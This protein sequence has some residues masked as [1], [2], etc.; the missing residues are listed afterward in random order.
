VLVLGA[1]FALSGALYAALATPW[2]R[3]EVLMAQ[4]KD[5][6]TDGLMS[7]FGGLASLA[8]INVGSSDNAEPLALLKS[9]GFARE[10][11]EEEKLETVLLSRKWNAAEKRWK[12]PEEDWPDVRD[13]VEYFDEKVRRVVPDKKTGLVTLAVEWK[14]PAVAA[15]WANKMASRLNN[16]MRE[17]AIAE[18]TE[19]IRYLKSEMAQADLIS[20][21][22]SI[23]KILEVELQKLMLA[24]NNQQ[25]S[26][27][28]IDPAQVPKKKVRPLVIPF[29]AVGGFLGLLLG[30]V[31]LIG[32]V[33]LQRVRSVS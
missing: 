18:S 30:V 23:G 14:D 2:Y 27:R 16:R 31:L 29:A 13:A 15:D 28:I 17:R 4:S 22:Q 26:F 32:R 20:L 12:G 10:F 25:Y 8:G 11:I 9:M 1:A 5:R 3:A 19:N 21:Q 33:V 24:R 7:Q 6:P